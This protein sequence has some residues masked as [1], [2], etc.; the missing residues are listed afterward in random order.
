MA[1]TK[2]L[3][4]KTSGTDH[5]NDAVASAL[6]T[7]E[8][9]GSGVAAIIAGVLRAAPLSRANGHGVIARGEGLKPGQ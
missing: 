4:A 8:A 9:E 3:M 2:P 6:R 7:L 5:A 1:K